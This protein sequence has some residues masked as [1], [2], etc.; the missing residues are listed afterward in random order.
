[1]YSREIINVSS[2]L[3]DPFQKNVGEILICRETWLW[4]QGMGEGRVGYL[5]STHME[6]FLIILCLWISWSDFEMIS[7]KYSLGDHFKKR[8]KKTFAKFLLLA[9]ACS[10]LV[11]PMF[12]AT[13]SHVLFFNPLPDMSILGFSNSASNKDMMSKIWTNGDTITWLS[14]KYCGKRRNCS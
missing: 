5:H 14:R 6:K 9:P 8:K 7:Q 11:R 4:W 12:L 3:S 2:S 13:T 10:A 1:M